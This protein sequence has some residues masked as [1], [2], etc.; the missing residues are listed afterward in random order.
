MVVFP[1]DRETSSL[2]NK[3]KGLSWIFIICL[4][5]IFELAP[6]NMFDDKLKC[7]PFNSTN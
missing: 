1:I 5:E 7:L 4:S 6:Q 2:S 3:I